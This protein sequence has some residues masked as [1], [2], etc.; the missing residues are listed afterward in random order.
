MDNVAM[1]EGIQRLFY[2]CD[3]DDERLYTAIE[4]LAQT[5]GER[6]YCVALNYLF[7][8]NFTAAQA[9][10]YWREATATLARPESPR[11]S[12]RAALLNYLRQKTNELNNPRIIEADDLE[13]IRRSAVTD[14]LTRL[15]NQSYFK[16]QLQQAIKLANHE[17]GQTF[18]ILIFDLDHFKQFND[19][20]GH[21]QGDQIL[22]KIGDILKNHT[23]ELDLPAR[24]GGEEFAVLLPDCNLEDAIQK[25]EEIRQLID[26]ESFSG[27]ERLDNNNLTISGGVACYPQHGAST[28][29]LIEAA[30]R[31]LYEAKAS[32]NTILPRLDD[33]RGA[34]RH[35][36]RNIVEIKIAGQQRFTSAL[37]SDISHTGLSL[38]SDSTPA[39]GTRV[40]LCFRYPFWPKNLETTGTVRHVGG[41][42][43]AGAF[44][45]GIQFDSP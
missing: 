12:F 6:A 41:T 16:Q 44:R 29:E 28:G 5:Q 38:K 39:I 37:S 18:S 43:A 20:C 40:E 9:G 10:H 42:P 2:S 22:R 34:S 23:G 7:G 25:A 26:V 1:Q 24:Y 19:R 8:K 45:L 30:D 13:E 4:A 21:L 31:R 36:F 35:Q 15:Y 32:R 14:G 17:A 11:Q 27:Q 33:T 3:E